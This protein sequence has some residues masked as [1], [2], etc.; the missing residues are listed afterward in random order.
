MC[1]SEGGLELRRR[2]GFEVEPHSIFPNAACGPGPP[3]PRKGDSSVEDRERGRRT[4]PSLPEG[5]AYTRQ[6]F[7]I[8]RLYLGH[9]PTS[10]SVLS[11]TISSRSPLPRILK[12]AFTSKQDPSY[13][14]APL[15]NHFRCPVL[16]IQVTSARCSEESNRLNHFTLKCE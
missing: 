12:A 11:L 6:N 2:D 8:V 5:G 13:C 3:G 7:E 9:L 4:C 1:G 14:M 15:S 10:C 16:F